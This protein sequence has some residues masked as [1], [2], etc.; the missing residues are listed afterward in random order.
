MGRIKHLL[1]TVVVL[2]LGVQGAKATDWTGKGK[3]VGDVAVTSGNPTTA[4]NDNIVYIYNVATGQFLNIGNRWGTELSLADTGTPFVVEK[5][6]SGTYRFVSSV[7]AE[8]TTNAS[9]S[10]DGQGYGYIGFMDGVVSTDEGDYYIDRMAIYGLSDF[11]LT[12]ISGLTDKDGNAVNNVYS[13]KFKCSN[14]QKDSKYNGNTY[15]MT[16]AT[17]GKNGAVSY[18]SASETVTTAD[19][20]VLVTKQQ[21]IDNFTSNEA[22]SASD[23][24]PAD[25]TYNIKDPQFNRKNGDVSSWKTGSDMSGTLS[26]SEFE[27]LPSSFCSD[28]DLYIYTYEGSHTATNH[29]L[30]GLASDDEK[31]HKVTITTAVDHG[32]TWTVECGGESYWKWKLIFPVF[33]SHDSEEITLTKNEEKTETSV[34]T[35]YYVG[36]GYSE[37][38]NSNLPTAG[39]YYCANIHGGGQIAQTLT[40]TTSGWYVVNCNGFTTDKGTAKLFFST[41]TNGEL[42]STDDNSYK[43]TE[44]TYLDD[45]PAYYAEAG[46]LIASSDYETSAMIYVDVPENSSVTL[47]FGV[48][49]N[50][51]TEKCAWACFD[52]FE[53]KYC[54]GK[55]D[56][57]LVL[58]DQETSM[59]YINAQV[60]AKKSY[61]MVLDRNLKA[62]QWNSFILPVSMTAQQFK[63]AFGGGAKLSAI[64]GMNAE[65][66]WYRL[67]FK[68]IDLSN[69]DATVL[70]AGKLYIIKPTIAPSYKAGKEYTVYNR[71]EKPTEFGKITTKNDYYLIN[72]MTLKA[73]PETNSGIVEQTKVPGNTETGNLTFKGTYINKTDASTV[74]AGSFLLGSDGKWYHS[75]TKS[76]P[77][78]GFRAWVEVNP[79]SGAKTLSIYNDGVEMGGGE[80]TAISE[81]LNEMGLNASGKVYNMNGQLVRSGSASLEGLQKGVYIVNGKK[82]IVK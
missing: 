32:D 7:K 14:G 23:A 28:K 34:S 77:S 42:G 78:K 21:L 81:V 50:G 20:W 22:A 13:M 5:Q 75:A 24:T 51:V 61:T 69:D 33:Y 19:Q 82:Y 54:G 15:Y 29:S 55:K 44:L 59:D 52:N 58:S 53:I 2:L 57:F 45:A 37:G 26:N 60:D 31:E 65:T 3:A 11:T 64:V 79:N 73:T 46:K 41:Y 18:K 38:D 16:S 30:L 68:S 40:V 63:L 8:N 1:I 66:N 71:D 35:N 17:N 70:E 72:Q 62:G 36:C 43:E 10:A 80:V 9:S 74:P 47:V 6:S 25:G 56:V 27:A 4:S 48:K 76:Y 39:G 49:V 67:N 12:E